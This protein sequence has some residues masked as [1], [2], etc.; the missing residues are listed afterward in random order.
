MART[1]TKTSR[2]LRKRKAKKAAKAAVSSLARDPLL[3]FLSGVEKSERRQMHYEQEMERTNKL[4]ALL[5]E[6][7]GGLWRMQDGTL[8][9]IRQ[10]SD[11]HLHNAI[12]HMESKGAAADSVA[13]MK[14][15]Q[16][17]RKV[18]R[19]W[20]G[21]TTDPNFTD[22]RTFADSGIEKR[23]VL[24][25]NALNKT[26]W[27]NKTEQFAPLPEQVRR[28]TRR[29]FDLE[30]ENKKL[31]KPADT[32]LDVRLQVTAALNTIRRQVGIE[33]IDVVRSLEKLLD[34]VLP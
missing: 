26:V 11:S 2:L 19:Q 27:D 17:R 24:L 14:A 5:E 10:M 29:I 12:R 4:L 22:G 9:Q 15:E 16:Q 23:L 6:S 1:R 13:K 32:A 3:D 28:L 18:D 25:E 31:R 21:R 33:N 8:I 34:R 7:T 20:A 30:Q